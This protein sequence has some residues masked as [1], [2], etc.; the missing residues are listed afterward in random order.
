M[1]EHT[2]RRLYA[3]WRQPDG[4]VHPVGMLTCRVVDSAVSFRFMYLKT[5][6]QLDGFDHLPGLSDLHRVYESDHL[7]AVF[8]NRQ[9]PR[10]RPDYGEYSAD[11]ISTSIPTRSMSWLEA[12]ASE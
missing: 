10:R 2:G 12:R 3:A 1:T 9:M 11:S 5:A 7:F 4:L 6:E 8:R